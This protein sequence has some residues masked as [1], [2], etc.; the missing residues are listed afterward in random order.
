MYSPSTD[1]QE[2]QEGYRRYVYGVKAGVPLKDQVRRIEASLQLLD[3]D[4]QD[5]LGSVLHARVRLKRDREGGCLMIYFLSDEEL[6]SIY[7]HIT[8]E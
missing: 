5:R 2:S 4:I 8:G 7:K 1:S 3:Q 6:Q